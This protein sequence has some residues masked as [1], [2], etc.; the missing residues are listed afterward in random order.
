MQVLPVEPGDQRAVLQDALMRQRLEKYPGDFSANY[1]LGDLL[2]SKGDAAGAIQY[3]QQASAA[4]PTSLIAATEWGVAL[5]TAGRLPEA[6]VEFQHVLTVDPHY[7]N[8]RFGLASVE[9][10]SGRFEAAATD[11]KQVL[12][13]RPDDAKASQHLGEVL[14]LW[15]DALAD[16]NPPDLEA[17]IGHYREALAYRPADPDLHT[18][19]GIALARSHKFNEA[20]VQFQV[21]LSIDSS[22]APARE[23]LAKLGSLHL[24][25]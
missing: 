16:A 21:A 19:L 17:A 22:F 11:F 24:K 7:A 6:E 8:A 12:S 14:I 4:S 20:Q 10:S 5:L 25:Q 18:T 13:E 9:A 23:A 1:N 2:L 15:G 3:F